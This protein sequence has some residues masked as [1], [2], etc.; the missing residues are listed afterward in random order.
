MN[1]WKKS[2]FGVLCIASENLKWWHCVWSIELVWDMGGEN[3]IKSITSFR[4]CALQLKKDCSDHVIIWIYCTLVMTPWSG[5]G[6]LD[7]ILREKSW[8]SMELK[9]K[10]TPYDFWILK[11][12]NPKVF[13][14]ND[15]IVERS[16]WNCFYN[17]VPKVMIHDTEKT[18]IIVLKVTNE[19]DIIKLP[20]DSWNG[21]LLLWFRRSSSNAIIARL[22]NTW[23][24]F[25][26]I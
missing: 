8:K 5:R 13:K 22:T 20:T 26:H 10:I 9:Y 19:N 7:V 2:V 17:R 6:E 15:R 21:T 23:E 12:R 3:C 25:L 18:N 14:C 16:I 4:I 1:W 11:L 24:N